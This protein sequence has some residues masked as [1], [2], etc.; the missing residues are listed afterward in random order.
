MELD[1]TASYRNGAKWG[2]IELPMP[3]GRT[4]STAEQRV[5]ELDEKTGKQS[6]RGVVSVVDVPAGEMVLCMLRLAFTPGSKKIVLKLLPV[7]FNAASSFG[8]LPGTA[9]ASQMHGPWLAPISHRLNASYPTLA[10]GTNNH[11]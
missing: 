2:H 10:D 7:A 8:W 4:M 5:H 9:A 11:H 1:D 3:F 6:C